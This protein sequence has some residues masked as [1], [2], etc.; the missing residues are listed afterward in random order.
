MEDEMQEFWLALMVVM[1]VAAIVLIPISHFLGRLSM[2]EPPDI[3]RLFRRRSHT[4]LNH[5]PRALH[6]VVWTLKTTAEP[7]LTRVETANNVIQTIIGSRPALIEAVRA[8]GNLSTVVS[9]ERR[10]QM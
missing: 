9:A 4:M 8:Y 6:G 1:A 2:R 5:P 10:M 7:D 3:T